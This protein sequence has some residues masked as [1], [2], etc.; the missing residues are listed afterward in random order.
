MPKKVDFPGGQ[1]KKSG[2]FVEGH[3]KID[4]KSRDQLEKK[5]KSL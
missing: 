4:R 3:D 5:E 1:G 2:K